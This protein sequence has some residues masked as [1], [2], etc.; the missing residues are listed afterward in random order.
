MKDLEKALKNLPQPN[1]RVEAFKRNLRAELLSKAS[2]QSQKRQ[3][4]FAVASLLASA[5][6]TLLVLFIANPSY[7]KKLNAWLTGGTVQPP[8]AASEGSVPSFANDQWRTADDRSLPYTPVVLPSEEVDRRYVENLL[9]DQA[10][11][12]TPRLQTVA[13]SGIY[14]VREFVAEDG[15]RVLVYT[16]VKDKNQPKPISISY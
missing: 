3:F 16:Q 11:G 4:G 1:I 5:F 2:A 12:R 13:S 10:S 9:T 7:P 14:T 8:M 6:A 15:K